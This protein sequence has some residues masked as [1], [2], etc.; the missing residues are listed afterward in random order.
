MCDEIGCVNSGL[1]TAV[2]AISQLL[3]LLRVVSSQPLTH[4]TDP[5][6][7][8]LD[9]D[10]L[11][12]AGLGNAIRCLMCQGYVCHSDSGQ[13]QH[14]AKPGVAKKNC[15]FDAQSRFLITPAGRD[16][17]RHL[18]ESL[19]SELNSDACA[20]LHSCLGHQQIPS[21]HFGR[22]SFDVNRRELRVGNASISSF[23]RSAHN[24]ITVLSAF[25]LEGWPQRIDDPL[26]WDPNIDHAQ[27]LHIT[28]YRLNC[29]QHPPV[30]RFL[31]DGTGNGI[32][33][34]FH[35]VQPE[36][37]DMSIRKV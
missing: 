19:M 13:Q 6:G 26:P 25:E 30:L 34:E 23:R 24:Q 27:R 29:H 11:Q 12:Q 15:Q 1:T 8:A 3:R 17:A 2:Q 21:P 33:W 32:R 7:Q 31:S 28:V 5:S 22:P 37:S 18:H 14:S 16:F 36:R 10:T 35:S 4:S 9:F 20:P